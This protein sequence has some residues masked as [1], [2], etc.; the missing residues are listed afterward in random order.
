MRIRPSRAFPDNFRAELHSTW[1][2]GFGGIHSRRS[3]LKELD[4]SLPPGYKIIVSGEQSKQVD[5][6][7]T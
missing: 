2:S 3:E 1:I 6:S 7:G 5:G 4:N